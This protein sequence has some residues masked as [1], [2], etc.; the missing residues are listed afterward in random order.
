M[1]L[2]ADGTGWYK[3]VFEKFAKKKLNLN[4][5]WLNRQEQ[6]GKYLMVFNVLTRI[7]EDIQWVL[8]KLDLE[9]NITC[10]P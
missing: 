8:S 7:P 10:Y 4:V 9:G 6:S 1:V 2:C 3:N 5:Q